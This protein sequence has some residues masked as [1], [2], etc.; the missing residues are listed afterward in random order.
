MFSENHIKATMAAMAE[1]KP[2][3]LNF[4]PLKLLLKN[5]TEISRISSLC[6]EGKYKYTPYNEK[7]FL[8]GRAKLPRGVSIPTY[9]DQAVLKCLDSALKEYCP[10][11][12][13]TEVA[14]FIVKRV[15]D[16]LSDNKQELVVIR[17]DI[18][19][20]F[21]SINHHI[22]IEK[23]H[24]KNC[25]NWIVELAKTAIKNPTKS[26]HSREKTK[27][28]KG[29]PQGVSIASHL[30]DLYLESFD[31]ECKKKCVAYF[32]YVDD[33][34]ILVKPENQHKFLNFIEAKLTD[35]GLEYHKNGDKF[36]IAT[37]G[38]EKGFDYLG[39]HFFPDFV[40]VRSVSVQKFIN[41][42]IGII[43]KYRK[44]T[45]FRK[46]R[47]KDI[48]R[49]AFVF[50][51]N[52]RISGALISNRRVGWLWYYKQM[53]DIKLLTKIDEII[54]KELSKSI[55][56]KDIRPKKLKRA[57]YEILKQGKNSRYILN[58][59]STDP[60][61]MRK[62][63]TDTGENVTTLDNNDVITLFQLI[64]RKRIKRLLLDEVRES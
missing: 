10:I 25:P 41:S 12:N 61:Y 7:L 4:H 28:F 36:Q 51:L 29:I 13:T 2:T 40:S 20:Y 62:V 23:M 45:Y 63:L 59:G 47:N 48:A 50:D 8:R 49:R 44:N 38:D 30:A 42:L 58:Y 1:K 17:L 5:E 27:R 32:R 22:L 55:T 53:N 43:T 56:T 33:I 18:V 37:L 3:D 60:V 6:R 31:Q 16:F 34:L 26:Q 15:K 39:Y 54:V 46:Y 9:K 24:E 19:A 21:E 57:Y 14:S 11:G 64:T 35:L 52:E